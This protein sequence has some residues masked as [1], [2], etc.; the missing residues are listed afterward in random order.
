[1]R[2]LI[3]LSDI[4]RVF[5]WCQ[6]VHNYNYGD[7]KDGV[8]WPFILTSSLIGIFFH[9]IYLF[10]ERSV[11]VTGGQLFYISYFSSWILS[12]YLTYNLCL[13]SNG[14]KLGE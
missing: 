7:T 11:G 4:I 13:K 9:G 10:I 2:L 8:V 5:F 12:A 6:H 14:F 3:S 1:M